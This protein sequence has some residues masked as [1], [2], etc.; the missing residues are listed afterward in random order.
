MNDSSSE[1]S[2]L[3]DHADWLKGL[4][5]RLVRDGHEAE[6]VFQEALILANSAELPAGVPARSWLAG[7]VR[8]VA[9][10]K[11]RSERRR[12]DHEQ[13]TEGAASAAHS[14]FDDAALLERQRALLT[15]VEALSAPQRRA[16]IARFYDGLPPRKIAAAEGVSV[17]TINSR[18][19]RGIEVLRERLDGEFGDRRTWAA[20]AVPLA[21]ASQTL[22]RVGASGF[23]GVPLSTLIAVLAALVLFSAGYFVLRRSTVALEDPLDSEMGGL[24]ADAGGVAPAPPRDIDETSP[25][26]DEAARR[27][28]SPRAQATVTVRD[29]KLGTAAAGVDVWFAPAKS[30]W[31][32]WPDESIEAHV[33]RTGARTVTDEEG[34]ATVTGELPMIVIAADAKRHGYALFEPGGE[35]L[36]LSLERA[37]RMTVRVEDRAGR[38]LEDGLTIVAATRLSG[39]GDVGSPSADRIELDRRALVHGAAGFQNP[40]SGSP[41][42]STVPSITSWTKYSIDSVSI[43][44]PGLFE[45]EPGTASRSV[46]RP[47]RRKPKETERVL[48]MPQVGVVRLELKERGGRRAKLNGTATV[49]FS[50]QLGPTGYVSQYPAKIVDGVARWPNFV[51]GSRRFNVDIEVPIRGSHWRVQGVGPERGDETATV[52]ATLPERPTVIAR[53]VDPTGSPLQLKSVSLTHGAPHG[54]SR[55]VRA[56]SGADGSVR[57]ELAEAKLLEPPYLLTAGLRTEGLGVEAAT[58]ID[59]PDGGFDGELDLGDVA[60][61]FEPV[62]QLNGVVVSED[63]VPV[64]GAQVTLHEMGRRTQILRSGAE[65]RFIVQATFAPGATLEI[66]H[67]GDGFL[68]RS[69]RVDA[70]GTALEKGE[71]RRFVL[72][73]GAQFVAQLQTGELEIE[74][75]Q[76]RLI[77]T[78]T[79]DASKHY[80]NDR[81]GGRFVL[82]RVLPGEYAA[83]V[84]YGGGQEIETIKGITVGGSGV[85]R[86]ERLDA[87]RA[88]DHLREVSVT[89]SGVPRGLEPQMSV[90][91]RGGGEGGGFIVAHSPGQ[92]FLLPKNIDASASFSAGLSRF[93]RIE[94]VSTIGDT[95]HLEFQEAFTATLLVRGAP[96][97]DSDYHLEG[98]GGTATDGA[99]VPLSG[100]GLAKGSCTV[101]VVVPGAYRLFRSEKATPLGNGELMMA[102]PQPTVEVIEILRPRAEADPLQPTLDITA[103]LFERD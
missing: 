31:E 78:R 80:P 68:P 21:G 103:G 39:F 77:L 17:S 18:I 92:P 34:R 25:A 98:L 13:R 90:V 7:V 24:R 97:P 60:L 84:Q 74:P 93:V 4:A 67:P 26:D 54:G 101:R 72:S 33:W 10:N 83:S 66:E 65:G 27:T 12:R 99:H 56:A 1:L 91:P 5:R 22:V 87:F 69:E 2:N 79:D 46:Y 43:D 3:L 48:V 8:N 58:A 63:G 95:L 82:S 96:D 16:V 51:V 55:S 11:Q 15:H 50:R 20:W 28:L 38:R 61:F 81:G 75:W 29:A 57:F 85:A 94:D 100:T 9:R 45:F 41:F 40:W 6:D 59:L 37:H 14:A 71:E 102:L 76:F 30:S 42:A 53:L 73:R 47:F 88:S 70:P 36:V 86:D 19:Q 52:R 62:R 32:A 23:M 44:G 35:E 64:S 89:W 49:S